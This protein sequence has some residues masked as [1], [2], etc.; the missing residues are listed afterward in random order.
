MNKIEKLRLFL[1]ENN[2]SGIVIPSNDP[3]FSEYIA[4]YW[5]TRPYISDFTGTA[6]TAVVT[7]E[8]AAV[9]VDSRYFIQAEEQCKENGFIVQKM[10]LA[11]TPIIADWLKDNCTEGSTIAVDGK[12]FSISSYEQLQYELNINSLDILSIED[13]FD[14]IWEERGSRPTGK[15]SIMPTEISGEST[16]SKLTRVREA[17]NLDGD[18]TH[19]FVTILDEISWLLN[20]RGEDIAF[21]PQVVSYAV[22]S[23]TKVRLFIDDN[24]IATN[25]IPY[26]EENNIEILPY[27]SLGSFIIGL[28]GQ[29]LTYTNKKTNIFYY[30]L[31]VKSGVELEEEIILVGIINRFKSIKN[32]TEIKGFEEAMIEDGVSLTKFFYWFENEMKA[33]NYSN[34]YEIGDL[35]IKFRSESELYLQ[36]SFAPIVGYKSNGALP[37]YSA[38]KEG[39]LTVKPEGFLLIDS[40]GQYS[41]GTTDITRT[42]H[43]STPTEQE[44]IDYTVVLKGMIDLTL[45][46]FPINTRGAQLDIIA[47]SAL[48]KEYMNYG[49]G[50]GHGLGHNLNVHEGPQSIRSE[51]N[52]ELIH[53]GMVM[54]NEPAVYRKGKYGIRCENVIV[55]EEAA[56]NDFG[57]FLRFRTMTMFP[58]DTTAIELDRLSK[59]Q[60]MWLNKYHEKVYDALSNSLSQE[61]RKWLEQRTK[62]I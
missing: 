48:L 14:S 10:G 18:N 49:H 20:I 16:M 19:Y 53:A 30:N 60:R 33:G 6:G 21:S 13:P 29:K 37:H 1:K 31:L 45:A 12:L 52:S 46:I 43:Y 57:E 23:G 58:F 17:L 4:S 9:W 44:K 42:V 35:L 28:K 7:L 47:R 51:M 59:E 26:F 54:S 25:D 32:K 5:K 56:K 15:I 24:K 34:E 11:G 40:G 62:A 27:D 3:H 39:S 50:T 61:E 36:D 22:V 38:K 55:C 2:L 41:C 8:S